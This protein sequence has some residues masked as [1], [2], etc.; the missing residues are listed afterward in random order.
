M[1]GQNEEKKTGG[2]PSS[3][4]RIK[5]IFFLSEGLHNRINEWRNGQ[6]V[7]PSFS[8]AIRALII[9]GLEREVGK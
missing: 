6:E 2:R 8:A 4:L 7:A 9:R 5:S 3:G 1:D